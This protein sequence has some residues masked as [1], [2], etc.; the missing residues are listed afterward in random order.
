MELCLGTVQLGMSYGIAGGSVFT[1]GESVQL[2]KEALRLGIDVF[3]TASAYGDAELVL[4]EFLNEVHKD[5]VIISKSANGINL[6]SELNR[7][8]K[9][10]GKS[11]IDGY[12]FHDAA[13]LYEVKPLKELISLREVGLADKI[14]VSIYK[15]EDAIY[16]AKQPWV[17]YIQI[18]YNALDQRLDRTDFFKIAKDNGKT[19]FA[20]SALLQGLL[21]MP[22]DEVAVKL[23]FALD[24][25]KKYLEIVSRFGKTQLEAAIE[26]VKANSNIDF[27][28]F[29][30]YSIDQLKEFVE[31]FRKGNID[32]NLIHELKTAFEKV[33]ERVLSPNQW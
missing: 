12:L 31:I 14:G 26:Y 16:A 11:K 24:V 28:I 33:N 22:L 27:L 32:D 1:R 5:C 19:I 13:L 3:D 9:V 29:G 2:L 23:G 20:R 10:L 6:S 17:D 25:I 7:T 21:T 15:P 4:G 8:L 18:P 30:V